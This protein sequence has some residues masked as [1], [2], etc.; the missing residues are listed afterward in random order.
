MKKKCYIHHHQSVEADSLSSA[1]MD[2]SVACLSSGPVRNRVQTAM[3]S[4][5][6]VI[7]RHLSRPSLVSL[8]LQCALEQLL[9]D[10]AVS[11]FLLDFKIKV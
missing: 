6:D 3:S 2:A 8:L 1:Q 7:Q 5:C 11:R 9:G 10:A 4:L